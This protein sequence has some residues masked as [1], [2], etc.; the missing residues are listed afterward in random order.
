MA[1]KKSMVFFHYCTIFQILTHCVYIGTTCVC[2]ASH[3]NGGSDLK[4]NFKLLVPLF[5]I[6][7][8]VQKIC[9]T[10]PMEH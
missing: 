5:V 9:G 6:F 2:N 7:S 8:L 3:C 1:G 10:I 4:A